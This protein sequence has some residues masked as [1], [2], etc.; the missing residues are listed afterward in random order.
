VIKTG[1]GYEIRGDPMKPLEAELAQ[2]RYQS[3][4][5]VPTFTGKSNRNAFSGVLD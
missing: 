2:Y 5:E 1:E 3:L 4:P